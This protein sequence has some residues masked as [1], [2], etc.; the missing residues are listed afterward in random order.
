MDGGVAPVWGWGVRWW[1][2]SSTNEWD[3]C[4]TAH[5]CCSCPL[6]S[7]PRRHRQCSTQ[8]CTGGCSINNS[9]EGREGG[10]GWRGPESPPKGSALVHWCCVVA[11]VRGCPAWQR[12]EPQVLGGGLRKRDPPDCGRQPPGRALHQRPRTKGGGGGG[13]SVALI[14]RTAFPFRGPATA[15][16]PGPS[17]VAPV[18]SSAGIDPVG[19]AAPAF[20]RRRS[21][22]AL[23]TLA[24]LRTPSLAP[25]RHCL[26]GL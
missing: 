12:R 4:P 18:C 14:R 1:K 20:I 17:T 22:V 7:L 23:Q 24:L 10:G 5:K 6:A 13:G 8:S 11:E 16:R 25:L 3:R 26:R 15:G 19:G 21:V 2:L 9:E